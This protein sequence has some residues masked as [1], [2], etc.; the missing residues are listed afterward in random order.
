MKY[1]FALCLLSLLTLASNSLLADSGDP[2]VVPDVDFTRYVGPWKEIA[3]SPNFFQKK[4][5]RS[6]A[7]YALLGPGK[8]SVHNICYKENGKT[9][10]IHGVATVTDPAVPAKLKVRFNFFARGDY[11]IVRLDPNYEWAVVSGPKRRSLFILS[12]EAPMAPALLETLLKDLA[13]DGFDTKALVF[14]K[15]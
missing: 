1:F 11:W 6:T 8:V 3:H 14:D 15:Y 5:L 12:R 9:S 4:C 10:D 2:S 13:A 7:E